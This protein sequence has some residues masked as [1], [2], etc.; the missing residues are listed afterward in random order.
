MR[1][2]AIGEH[3]AQLRNLD[4]EEFAAVADPSWHKAI[5]LRNVIAHGYEFIDRDTVWLILT[6][7]LP[8]FAETIDAYMQRS[9]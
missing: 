8:P 3:L 5:G 9:S 7:D 6:E 2:H 4:E 1:L